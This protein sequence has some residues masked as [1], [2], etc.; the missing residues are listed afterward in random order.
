MRKVLIIG[1]SGAGKSTLA[2]K[3]A[4]LTGLPLVHLDAHFW[5]TGWQETPRERWKERVGELLRGDRWVMDGNYRGTLPERLE[6]ADTV[7]LLALSRARCLYRA[8]V[9]AVRGYGKTRPDL[10]PGCPEHLPDWDFI[11]WIWMFPR[12]ELPGVLELLRAYE[13]QRTIVILRSPSDVERY[14]A[15]VSA[16]ARESSF[17]SD[18]PAIQATR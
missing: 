5:Q 1:S 12:N 3:L 2:T 11:R 14:L 16:T 7:I 15:T 9:R 10:H 17:R 4:A 18:D 13:G 6:A 8:V